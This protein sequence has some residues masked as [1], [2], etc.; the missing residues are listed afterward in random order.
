MGTA[1]QRDNLRRVVYVAIA[2]LV[3]YLGYGIWRA[4]TSE[5]PP[6]PLNAPVIFRQGSA[7]GQRLTGRSWS[8]DYDRIVTNTD[9]T[10]LELYGVKHGVIFRDGKPYLRVTADRMTVNTVTHD[11]FITGKLHIETVS[12]DPHRTFDTDEAT[13]S[14]AI[15]TLVLPNRAKIGTGADLPLLV[16]SAR[17]NVKTGDLELQNVAGAVRFK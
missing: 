17:Y 14:D 6:P 7:L 4:G 13:W 15:Q 1:L 2:A 9:Q 16:G 10:I 12:S 8:A 11:F 5:T 3:G